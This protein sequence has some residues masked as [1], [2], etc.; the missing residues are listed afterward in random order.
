MNERHA[1][2]GALASIG[3]RESISSIGEL[4][5]GCIHRVSR[6]GLGPNSAVIAKTN[7]E[8]RLPL[9]E[10]EAA[11]LRALV[12]TDTV[13]V[14]D[15]VI[16]GVFSGRAVF[17][18]TELPTGRA[19]E[20][21]WRR[22]GEELAALHDAD[23][24]AQ[25]G[26]DDDNHLGATLQPNT[27]CSDW[28]QFNRLHRIGHQVELARHRSLLGPDE[29]R[30]LER[31]ITRLDEILPRHP[32]PA[33][34]HG[35]LWSGNAVPTIDE[36][37]RARVGVIDPACSVGDGWADVAMMRL[38]GGFPDACLQGYA[39]CV[40]DHDGI[41]ERVAVYQLYHLLNHVNLFGRGYAQQAMSIV[42]RLG[43]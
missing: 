8:D 10:E 29:V 18:M 36:H 27:W 16:T 1:I 31:C 28:I 4:G 6:V 7:S 19:D 14:P 21:T 34:L 2:Q 12:A 32:V 22:F 15:P 26:F 33:L 39:A 13:L 23:A 42:A 37:G 11:G 5:G 9:F 38:F 40:D 24:G 35:D 3:R 20:T 41:E 43:A 17:L 30:R 25:Y